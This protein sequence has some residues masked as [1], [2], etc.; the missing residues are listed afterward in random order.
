MNIKQDPATI[1]HYV[2][3]ENTRNKDETRDEVHNQHFIQTLLNE[4]PLGPKETELTS[5]KYSLNRLSYCTLFISV[6]DRSQSM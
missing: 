2:M 4:K 3:S 5:V 6:E 1:Y